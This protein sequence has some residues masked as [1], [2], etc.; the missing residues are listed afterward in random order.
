MKDDPPARSVG[1]PQFL[2]GHWVAQWQTDQTI[3]WHDGQT[4]G[5]TSYLGLDRAH[6][7]AVIVLSDVA[8]DLARPTWVSNSSPDAGDTSTPRRGTNPM[9]VAAEP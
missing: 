5:Y 4:A 2:A 1:T 9:V 6:H 8:V 7:T 3:T